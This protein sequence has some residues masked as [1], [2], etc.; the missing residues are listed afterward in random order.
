MILPRW[1]QGAVHDV[2]FALVLAAAILRMLRMPRFTPWQRWAL[3]V[4]SCWR[5]RWSG[6]RRHS[7]PSTRSPS[8]GC[9]SPS[10]A[11]P[12]TSATFPPVP[13]ANDRIGRIWL[14]LSIPMMI[15]VCLRW[16]ATL[17]GIDLG[18]PPAQFGADAALKVLTGRTRSSSRGAPPHGSFLAAAGPPL[19]AADAGGGAAPAV[20]GAAE[21]A[22]GLAHDRRRA[23]RPHGAESQALSGGRSRWSSAPSCSPSR[24]RRPGCGLGAEAAVA[25][26]AV[27]TGT[28][29]WRIQG[30]SELL[31]G[32]SKA[33][34]SGD[35]RASRERLRPRGA[36]V[37]GAGGAHTTSTSRPL[38]RAGVVGLL[39]LI[40]LT[41]WVAPRAV[42]DPG[43][44][45]ADGLL[46]PGV[47]PALLAM[48]IV[49]F[50]TWIPGMEQGSSPVSR[51][52]WWWRAAAVPRFPQP[53]P[54]S[55]SVAV[56][57]PPRPRAGE[58]QGP[59][60]SGREAEAVTRAGRCVTC[61]S[62]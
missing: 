48:Q 25:T 52:A 24:V 23:G 13:P 46:A 31:A 19:T 3:L 22:H 14:A 60:G 18:V 1:Y 38:L 32:L 26:S 58:Q 49:W 55:P 42:A 53:R 11:A 27:G 59:D 37:R 33:R 56:G 61:G 47:F 2:A 12:S 40:A 16:L 6:E 34:C 35:R 36:G 57:P 41:G 50:L 8:S 54:R 17:A 7:V 5:F 28:L 4:A 39:A 20:R 30:W 9:S 43:A 62:G 51:R 10:S 29:D 45:W 15:L 44:R 21:P